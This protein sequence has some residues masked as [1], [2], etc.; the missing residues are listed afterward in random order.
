MTRED[1]KSCMSCFRDTVNLSD[2]DARK[3]CI[4]GVDNTVYYA[5]M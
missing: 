2:L 5:Y 1:L 3:L 4:D